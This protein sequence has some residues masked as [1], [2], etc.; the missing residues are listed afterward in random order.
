MVSDRG[1]RSVRIADKN[2]VRAH[3]VL[4]PA[5]AT[6]DVS[7]INEFLVGIGA[8][9]LEF[10]DQKVFL[11]ANWEAIVA[12]FSLEQREATFQ[13]LSAL[14][15]ERLKR[16]LNPWPDV[17]LDFEKFL[18]SMGLTCQLREAPDGALGERLMQY[19][20]DKLNVKVTSKG[21]WQLTIADS[22]CRPDTWY[23][24]RTIRKMLW[25]YVDPVS[26]KEWF[27]FARENW[28]A[29]AEMFAVGQADEIHRY[30]QPLEEE[31]RQ[32]L[33]LTRDRQEAKI[34]QLTKLLAQPGILKPPLL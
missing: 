10:F 2:T 21:G 29:I 9:E 8:R 11:H 17:I 31:N 12:M 5:P 18:K 16:I 25:G 19:H 15:R 33:Q 3:G 13:R 34:E 32:R 1:H 20:G 7:L 27:A 28:K 26:F 24:I 14:G 4:P 22:L 30:L 23:D 6:Y